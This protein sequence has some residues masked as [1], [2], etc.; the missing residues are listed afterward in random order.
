MHGP[1]AGA[2]VRTQS[3][4]RL[5]WMPKPPYSLDPDERAAS[6]ALRWILLPH[7]PFA[8]ASTGSPPGRRAGAP[9]VCEVQW[10]RLGRGWR[11]TAM[12]TTHDG[13]ALTRFPAPPARRRRRCGRGVLRTEL[14]SPGRKSRCHQRR[15]SHLRP[16]HT[17]PQREPILKPAVPLHAPLNHPSSDRKAAA[18]R[19][20]LRG[21]DEPARTHTL[22]VGLPSPSPRSATTASPGGS[23]CTAGLCAEGEPGC[24]TSIA[25]V[26]TEEGGGRPPD[27][28]R[29]W[30][31]RWETES[32]G[33]ASPWHCCGDGMSQPQVHGSSHAFE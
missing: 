18:S 12:L 23:I 7:R 15:R 26:Y 1:Q 27:R 14:G 30:E 9:R 24:P 4:K 10:R 20:T 17:H 2:A 8:D 5:D 25:H 33:T 11:V 22:H 3:G 13:G 19:Q 16:H 21:A 31:A 28:E 32:L 6:P 29:P